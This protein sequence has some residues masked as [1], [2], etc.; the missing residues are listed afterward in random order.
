MSTN[1]F[2]NFDELSKLSDLSEGWSFLNFKGIWKEE[3]KIETFK[4]INE[5]SQSL[6][7]NFGLSWQLD[8]QVIEFTTFIEDLLDGSNWELNINKVSRLS[9]NKKTFFYNLQSFKDWGK[10][11]NPFDSF[12][13]LLSVFPITII[14]NNIDEVVVANNYIICS[15]SRIT[16]FKPVE[17]IPDFSEINSTVHIATRENFIVNP[18]KLFISEGLCT[19]AT[20][21]FFEM[22]AKSLAVCLVSEIGN[23]ETIILRG[24][25]KIELPLFKNITALNVEIL[26]QLKNSVRWV[27]DEKTDLKIKLFLDRFTLDVDL[28]KDYVS[29]LIRL[30][31]NCLEQAKERF[32]FITFE[33]KDQFQKELRDLLKDLKTVSDLYSTKARGL[34]S[35]LLRDVLAGLLLIGITILSKVDNVNS[36]AQNPVINLV[37]KAFAI[38]FILSI[39]YQAIF[40][41]VD[42]IKTKNEFIYWKQTSREYISESEFKVYLKQTVGKREVFTYVY[43]GFLIVTYFLLAY[44][45]YNFTQ[46]LEFAVK[47]AK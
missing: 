24:I 21:P 27:Y 7:F 38:Y 47:N 19:D 9:T 46:Y 26:N 41:L 23:H 4:T 40:D 31:K 11:L 18:K 2:N 28:Q 44:L 13:P 12:N 34:L 35:N 20:A 3:Y 39:L 43:Y 25:R 42:I 1:L 22:S 15:P 17:E 45:S 8:G 37:F 29:E 5:L 36:V 6:N 14:V 33:R 10:A 30:N 32:S 16:D